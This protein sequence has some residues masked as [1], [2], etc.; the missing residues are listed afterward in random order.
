MGV[1]PQAI[2]APSRHAPVDLSVK[3]LSMFILMALGL[4]MAYVA[5]KRRNAAPQRTDPKMPTVHSELNVVMMVNG[6]VQIP[7]GV[8]A[9]VRDLA[10]LAVLLPLAVSVPLQTPLQLLPVRREC[11]ARAELNLL[12]VVLAALGALPAQLL[13]ILAKVFIIL[14]IK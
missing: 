6:G 2:I 4:L 11:F 14:L 3:D 13:A 9:L 10:L 7:L 8:M 5:K 1:Y 12:K